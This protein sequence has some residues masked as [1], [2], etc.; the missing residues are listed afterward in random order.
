MMEI[1]VKQSSRITSYSQTMNPVGIHEPLDT[2]SDYKLSENGSSREIDTQGAW[3]AIMQSCSAAQCWLPFNHLG[4]ILE[5]TRAW[6]HTEPMKSESLGGGA[7]MSVY[8]RS[9]PGD[10]NVPQE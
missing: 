5:N 8:F 7:Q 9:S 10:S 2:A 6:S 4:N 1:T 3:L